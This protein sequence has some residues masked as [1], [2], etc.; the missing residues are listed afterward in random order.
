MILS[1]LPVK[2]K[3]PSISC[4]GTQAKHEYP[5]IIK[6]MAAYAREAHTGNITGQWID[7]SKGFKGHREK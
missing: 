1:I 4:Q 7:K 6:Q 2:S 3:L 5:H